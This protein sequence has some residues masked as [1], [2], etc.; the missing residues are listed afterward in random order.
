MQ[1]APPPRRA[2]LL[3]AA[4]LVVVGLVA[5]LGRRSSPPPSRPPVAA[6]VPA[7]PHQAR[8]VG[9]ID[10]GDPTAH[11]KLLVEGP[12]EDRLRRNLDEYK[13]VAVYPP[14][15][16]AFTAGTKYLLHWN[17]PVVQDLPMDDR[18]GRETTYHFDADRAH[19][20]YGEAIT[21]WIEVWKNGDPTD[22]VP[23]TVEDAWVIASNGPQAG[24]LVK[25]S[26]HDDGQDGDEVA[27]DGRYTNRFV[28]SSLPQLKQA[29]QVHLAA[30]VSC[31]DGVRRQFMREFDY[32]PRAV[33]RV[34]GVSDRI[35]D[36]SLAVT[37]DLDVAERGT[38][39]FEANLLSADGHVPIG[40]SQMNATLEAGRRTVD[41]VF[42][43]RM[44]A[45]AGSDGPYLVRDIRG[46]LLSLDGGEHNIWFTYDPPYLT[47]PYKRGDFSS[48]EWDA[49]EKQQKIQ[50]LQQLISA[51]ASGQIGGA[52]T[53]P[54]Q[55]IQIDQNGVA[56]TI[57]VPPP[58]AR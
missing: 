28:P 42:F 30:T 4:A 13:K 5:W 9:S 54:T 50:A 10:R 53:G 32:A 31:C 49:P 57:S 58:P 14:W 20:G 2:L 38:F 48:A 39:D 36:G 56:H 17:K 16:R 11:P 25:L 45:E 51:T 24:R 12:T 22:R 37:L 26:Y 35:K 52:P 47:Q 46:A 1:P 55:A 43:G 6:D 15:S 7:A 23:I 41:L 33:V 44:F 8:V 27:G 3:V 18:P 34:L 40:Y 19:V 29:M 21:S